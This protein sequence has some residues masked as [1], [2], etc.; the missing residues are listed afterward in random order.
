MYLYHLTSLVKIKFKKLINHYNNEPNTI[1]AEDINVH[2][3]LWE[4][5][6]KNDKAGT[7]V[8]EIIIE[9]N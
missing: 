7:I 5:E 8:A 9:F 4:L 3:D 6:S 2:T 1:I